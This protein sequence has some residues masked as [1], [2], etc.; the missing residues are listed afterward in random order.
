MKGTMMKCNVWTVVI[1]SLLLVVGCSKK[2]SH[3][4]HEEKTLQTASSETK[5]KEEAELYQC[6]MHPTIIRDRPGQCPICGMDLV[7]VAQEHEQIDTEDAKVKSM[8][9]DKVLGPSVRVSS[10]VVQEMSIRTQ[11]VLKQPFKHEVRAYAKVVP[12]ETLVFHIHPKINGWI[13]SLNV[14]TQG[15]VVQKGTPILTFYSPEMYAAF[16]DYVT[17][18]RSGNKL[19]SNS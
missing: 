14:Y 16:Q 19:L 6:P 7:P 12:D 10:A 17:A 13:E 3:S 11:H 2:Q 1:L 4:G 9:E 5:S 18:I 8:L 15:E